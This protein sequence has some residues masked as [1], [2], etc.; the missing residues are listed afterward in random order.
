MTEAKLTRKDLLRAGAAGGAAILAAPYLRPAGASAAAKRMNVLVFM[1]DQDRAIQHFP[2]GWAAQNLPGLT[3]LQR[4]GLTF[5]NAFTNAC[6]CSPARSTL[7]S[8]FYPAQ[9]GVKY[10]LEDDMPAGQ[11]PQVELPTSLANLATVAAAAGY[12]PVYKGKWHCSK[13]TATQF[14][15]SDIAR[16]GFGRWNP[17]DAGANQAIDQ[18]GG[19]LANHDGRYMTSTGPVEGGS[20][21]VL[22]Y[23]HSGAAQDQPFFLVVS[24]VNPHDVL[25]YPRGYQQ[26]GYDDSWLQGSIDLPETVDEDLSTKP[27]A[28]QRFLQ[29]SALGA[30][31]PTPEMKRA[32]LNFYGNLMKASD[33]YL[34]QVLDSLKQ[35]GLLANTLVVRTA[36]HGEMGLAHGGLRQKNF[37][38]YEESIRVPLVYSNPKLY[39]RAARSGALVSHVDFLPTMASLVGAPKS[40]RAAWRGIDYSKTVL[41][42]KGAPTRQQIVFTYDDSQAGQAKGPYIPPPNHVVAVRETRWKIAKYY[43]ADGV[44]PSEWELYDLKND[45][46]E[47]VN[48][49]RPGLSLTKEQSDALSRM[50]SKLASV[51]ATTLK[52]LT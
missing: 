16:Y 1:T 12:T 32:Y 35:T 19:G 4:N 29:L 15:P 18:T 31:L 7:M 27:S 24:L 6:M 39:P 46:A 23:L 36:D 5:T 51:V 45:P 8:G 43:D 14:A 42:K 30:P 50:Q 37:N 48:L 47:R 49:A 41:G 20:E 33:R 28:Q 26:A 44:V 34:V 52:P 2:A 11:Y 17:P 21:G 13:P 10:T 40:A 22:Q 9:H 38:A 25:L 3:R